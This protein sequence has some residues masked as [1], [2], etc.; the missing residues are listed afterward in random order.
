[1]PRVRLDR[2]LSKLGLAS[3]SEAQQLIRDGRVSV[4]GRV[5]TDPASLVV[6][7]AST[8]TVVGKEK[9]TRAW[10][11]IALNKPRGVVTT[12]SDPEGRK[13]VFDVLGVDAGSLVAV[14]RLDMASTGLLLLTTDTQLAAWLT[15]P[16]NEVVRRYVVTARGSVSDEAARE[17][18]RGIGQLSARSVTVRK[19]SKKETHLIV[20]LAEGR[21]REIRRLLQ[22]V[23]HE[24]TRLLRV[25]FGAV[26][27]GALQPGAWRDIERSEI[28]RAFP[29]TRLSAQRADR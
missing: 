24:V 18:E 29:A 4:A 5:H 21:N 1:M 13:T 28:D 14:G 27:L 12:R 16:R 6:P 26:E 20:E 10:R 15:D 3:R 25:S 17:M 9:T 2:A 22:A 8:I 7:E 19:R 11:T 23:G